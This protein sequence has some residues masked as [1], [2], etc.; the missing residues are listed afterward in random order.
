MTDIIN[1]DASCWKDKRTDLIASMLQSI[2]VNCIYE[3]QGFIMYSSKANYYIIGPWEVLN[4]N[5]VVA[6]KLLQSALHNIQ[7]K[8]VV[9]DSPSNNQVAVK[10]LINNGFSVVSSTMFMCRGI[11]PKIKFHQI[12]AYASLGSMG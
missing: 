3:L 7:G 11:L 1:L 5:D 8:K 6:Q 2:Y 4:G 12:F 9:L 10:I